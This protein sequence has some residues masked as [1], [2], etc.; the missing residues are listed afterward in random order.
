M[1]KPPSMR[2]IEEL[3][4]GDGL[5]APDPVNWAILLGPTQLVVMD[6]DP[7]N[8][9]LEGLAA[10]EAKYGPL[11]RTAQ[12][13]SGGGGRHYYFAAP[14]AGVLPRCTSIKLAEGVELL[15]G[16]PALGEPG[17]PGYA[18]GHNHVVIVAP[19]VHQSGRPYRW[20]VPPWELAPVAPPQW[21][22]DL[23]W[24]IKNAE[25][26]KQPAVRP[27]PPPVARPT[28]H[29]HQSGVL[30]RADAYMGRVPGTSEV[31]DKGKC[32]NKTLTAARYLVYGFDLSVAEAL[33]LFRYWNCK[34]SPPWSEAELLHKLEDAD[35]LPDKQG[36]ARGYL[37]D[38]SRNTY[39]DALDAELAEIGDVSGLFGPAAQPTADASKLDPCVT[40]PPA[41]RAA[42]RDP[43]A[44]LENFTV[45]PGQ[46]GHPDPWQEEREAAAR[47]QA[48]DAEDAP[49]RFQAQ[50]ERINRLAACL[51]SV[52]AG[53][54]SDNAL[55]NLLPLPRPKQPGES[56][57]VKEARWAAVAVMAWIEA[58]VAAAFKGHDGKGPER[59]DR[60]AIGRPRG[61][62]LKDDP[63]KGFFAPLA[64]DR[65]DCDHCLC[66][67]RSSG[68]ATP[69]RAFFTTCRTARTAIPVGCRR[70][71]A[72]ASWT[73]ATTCASEPIPFT[74]GS[75]TWPNR[76]R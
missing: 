32:H 18:E 6:V 49:R 16:Y 74:C 14:A 42:S 19:S 33:P 56:R 59:S 58:T 17:Q 13:Q 29:V 31:A 46:P 70:K 62:F 51:D 53:N 28:R 4:Y 7:R 40:A 47:R 61:Y 8:G 41:S 63:H 24:S 10:L 65:L 25:A 76:A 66:R 21:F 5:N 45:A 12:D 52:L 2:G 34:C 71:L 39:A 44:G 68:S 43:L 27:T 23:A 35:K 30:E 60:C 75:A 57:T 54:A 67:L 72:T 38:A 11:P 73:S 69:R 15:S 1:K 3:L 9:G 26:V 55:Q 50:H 37:R 64:C 20:T 36:R 22:I 48:E